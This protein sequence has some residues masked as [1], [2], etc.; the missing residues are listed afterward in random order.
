MKDYRQQA[1]EW[2]EWAGVV[3]EPWQVEIAAEYFRVMDT[4]N[5]TDGD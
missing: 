2:A 5:G 4:E 1:L 3:W